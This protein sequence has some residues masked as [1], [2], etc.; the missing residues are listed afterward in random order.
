MMSYVKKI[1]KFVVDQKVCQEISYSETLKSNKSDSTKHVPVMNKNL[2]LIVIPK[3]KQNTDKT[4][5]D[6]NTKVNPIDLKIKNVVD[7]NNG[8]ILIE[9]DTTENRDKIRNELEKTIQTDYDIKIPMDLKPCF[10][11]VH[12]S[13]NFSESEI[14]MKL[15]KQ[16]T[17]LEFSELK[18]V[19]IRK[20]TKFNKELTNAIIEVDKLCF[21]KIIE[22]EKLCIGWEKCKVFDAINVR[23]CN[24]CKGYNHK[25]SECKNQET[26][27]KCH[28]DHKTSTCTEKEE[29]KECINCKK[30]N[31]KFNVG[32]KID[33]KTT[34]FD[35]P[36]YQN[37]L[38]EKKAK[39]GY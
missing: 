33:H 25:S 32:V 2:P 27:L 13:N 34:S 15:K 16:N 9:T 26:C 37:K 28:K 4:K 8:K 35:C 17:F 11:I 7:R 12:M 18:V 29:L 21:P 39:I 22:A 3:N 24:K 19:K 1:D 20:F 10:E 38:R 5:F 36:V 14:I 31:E 30:A 23:R 6:L